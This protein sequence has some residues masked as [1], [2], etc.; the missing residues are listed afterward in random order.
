MI[1]PADYNKKLS[2]NSSLLQPK[3]LQQTSEEANLETLSNQMTKSAFH[4]KQKSWLSKPIPKPDE[5]SSQPRT[6]KPNYNS[7]SLKS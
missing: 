4:P 3:T 2:P 7:S 1:Q 6:P 5:W